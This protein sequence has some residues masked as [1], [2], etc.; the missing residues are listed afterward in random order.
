M[1]GSAHGGAGRPAGRRA[2][3]AGRPL[4]VVRAAWGAACLLSP[5]RVA[6]LAGDDPDRRA[7][8]VTR[9]LGARHLVQAAF[10]LR[11]AGPAVLAAGTWVDV[12]HA[13]TAVVLAVVDRRRARSALADAAVA[14]TWAV[15]GRRDVGRAQAVLVGGEPV[16]TERLARAVLPWLPGAPAVPRPDGGT[17]RR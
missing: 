9:V 7:V 10:T 5:R 1:S 8:V 2:P 16:W 3:R 15:L 17:G 13:A 12:V 11:A 6:A 4:E 14:A